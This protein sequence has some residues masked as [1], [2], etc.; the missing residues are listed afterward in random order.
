MNIWIDA[1]LSPALAQWMEFEFGIP[2]HA[3]RELGLRDAADE[4]I[5]QSARENDVIIM[6]KDVDFARLLEQKGSPPKV[7]WITC[8]NT[9]NKYLKI[10]LQKTLPKAISFLESGDELVEISDRI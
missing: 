1:Q 5:F 4:V 2:T 6:T 3:V 10:L 8:G 9:S 7:I